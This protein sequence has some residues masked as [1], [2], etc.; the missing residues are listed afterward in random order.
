MLRK[1]IATCK[2]EPEECSL[3]QSKRRS[4]PSRSKDTRQRPQSTSK[5][6]YVLP[7]P[8]DNGPSL[9]AIK[10]VSQSMTGAYAAPKG[11][12]GASH[13]TSPAAMS[14]SWNGWTLRSLGSS[15]YP[16]GQLSTEF[17]FV[18]PLAW[19]G[20][21]MGHSACAVALTESSPCTVSLPRLIPQDFSQHGGIRLSERFLLQ[22]KGRSSG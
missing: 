4:A 1:N 18:Q 16:L 7:W 22:L 20:R 6:V 15:T 19:R 5:A 12:T 17:G 14:N 13:T 9:D 8:T 10:Q 2:E 21:P 11:T 3:N